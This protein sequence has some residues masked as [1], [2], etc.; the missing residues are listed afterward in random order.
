[1]KRLAIVFV[2]VVCS[3]L[4]V[5]AAM[6]RTCT[7]TVYSSSDY[8]TVCDDGWSLYHYNPQDPYSYMMQCCWFDMEQRNFRASF[9][10]YSGSASTSTQSP[11]SAGACVS[12]GSSGSSG[13]TGILQPSV[14]PSVTPSAALTGKIAITNKGTRIGKDRSTV[15]AI[16][17]AASKGNATQKF[18]N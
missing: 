8:T 14:M 4:M 13:T 17:Q 3:L 11:N 9:P 12:C 5:S 6:G 18:R 2:L 15:A 16:F 10:N 1:M 7:T